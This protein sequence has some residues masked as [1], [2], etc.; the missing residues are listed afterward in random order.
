MKL[1]YSCRVNLKQKKSTF[2]GD[3]EKKKFKFEPI[4]ALNVITFLMTIIL[5]FFCKESEK[6][7]SLE[8]L[9]E[10]TI[11]SYL[12]L[13]H[14]LLY[15]SNKYPKI[16][17]FVAERMTKFETDEKERHKNK[18]EDLG[19]YLIY[20]LLMNEN[21]KNNNKISNKVKYLILSETFC[22]NIFWNLKNHSLFELF[23][24]GEE[25]PDEYRL[26]K[27]FESSTVSFS[28]VAFNVIFET[29]K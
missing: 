22:R 11:T 7:N 29:K 28:I 15:L 8:V 23:C 10:D 17:E 12:R 1:Y 27:T 21:T 20:Y 16:L 14:I 3:F 18:T 25:K 6:S 24:L 13:Y 26:I 2:F 4:S 5:K 9:I 19:C